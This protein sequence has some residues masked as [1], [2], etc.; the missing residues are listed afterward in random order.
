MD[1]LIV[2]ISIIGGGIVGFLTSQYFWERDKRLI[3]PRITLEDKK[4]GNDFI[5][6]KNEGGSFAECVIYTIHEGDKKKQVSLGSSLVPDSTFGRISIKTEN[7]FLI[8][9]FYKDVFGKKYGDVWKIVHLDG[10]MQEPTVIRCLTQE[11]I[12]E[13]YRQSQENS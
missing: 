11:E 10:K 8:E 5:N 9:V 6:F 1:I 3:R 2:L 13:G 12:E 4:C 7:D